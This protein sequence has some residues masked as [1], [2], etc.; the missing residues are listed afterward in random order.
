MW[1]RLKRPRSTWMSNR[2]CSRTLYAYENSTLLLEWHDA[3]GDPH[4]ASTVSAAVVREFC[5]AWAEGCSDVMPG[6]VSLHT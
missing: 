2:L 4:V 6:T 1:L 5:S 3:F